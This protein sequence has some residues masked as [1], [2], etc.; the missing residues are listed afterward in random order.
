MKGTLK[1]IKE[2]LR[3]KKYESSFR[4]DSLYIA[5][6]NDLSREFDVLFV[7]GGPANLAGARNPMN[8]PVAVT[9]SLLTILCAGALAA[10]SEPQVAEPELSFAEA[11]QTLLIQAQPGDIIEVPPG[12]HEFTRSLSLTVP[13][14]TIRGAGRLARN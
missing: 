13:N 2:H 12:V 9:K 4:Y 10:C 11:F 1:A 5:R 14:V 7:G 6:E 3:K 8:H